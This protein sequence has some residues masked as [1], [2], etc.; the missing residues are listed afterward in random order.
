MGKDTLTITLSGETYAIVPLSEYEAL[1][2][3]ADEDAM[4]AGIMRRVL[5]DPEQEWIPAD[6]LRRM[7][8]GEH[9]VRV[10]R[11]YRGMTASALAAAAGIAGSYLSAIEKGRKPGSMNAMKRIARA[12]DVN[13]D[14]LV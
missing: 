13:L 10:W 12:L 6:M 1:H 5:Q 3:A 2:E 11:D 14:D 7:A 8:A 9:P 4:D